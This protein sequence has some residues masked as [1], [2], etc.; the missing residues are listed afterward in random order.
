MI[1]IYADGSSSGGSNKPGGYGFVIVRGQ[2]VLAWSYGG[3]PSTTNNLMETEGAI[4]GLEAALELKLHEGS[5]MIEL[6]SDSQ[7]TL[8]IA[9]G[10]YSPQKNLDQAQK[11]VQLAQQVK[12]RFRWVKGHAGDQFNEHCDRLAKQGKLENTLPSVRAKQE[13][14]SRLQKAH[15][16]ALKQ[17][18]IQETESQ[19]LDGE[20]VEE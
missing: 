14:R 16:K 3:S 6:V 2:E 19:V 17:A 5:E 1:S 8:G 10:G 12:C 20:N 11:L 18:S 7:Y 4:Q 15:R 9:S 13:S